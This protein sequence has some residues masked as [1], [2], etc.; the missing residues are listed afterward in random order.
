MD[1][2][3]GVWVTP[4]VL[5]PGVALLVVSTSARY[6]QI[7]GEFHDLREHIDEATLDLLSHLS[8]RAAL[9]RSALVSLYLSTA[10]LALG[11]LIGGVFDI[12]GHNRAYMVTAALLCLGILCLVFAAIQLVRESV[13]SL[14]IINVHCAS[15]RERLKNEGEKHEEEQA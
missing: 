13:R 6:G 15:I 14:H 1:Q 4:L 8:A 11:A 3:I 10:L 12:I 7:L 9:F 5:M 2:D